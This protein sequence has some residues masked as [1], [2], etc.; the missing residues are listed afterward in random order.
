MPYHQSDLTDQRD[1]A[2]GLARR[3]RGARHLSGK[4]APEFA[5]EC[6]WSVEKLYKIEQGRQ[7]PDALELDL[8][9]RATGQPVEFFY[10]TTSPSG[11]GARVLT[12]S[13]EARKS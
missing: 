4:K 7:V 8:I 2:V 13:E 10:G 1:L 9:A 5:R 6:G 11:D 3:V 12:G